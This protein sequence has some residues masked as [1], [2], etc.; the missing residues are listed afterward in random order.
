MELISKFIPYK[1]K[2]VTLHC[3]IVILIMTCIVCGLLQLLTHLPVWLLNQFVLPVS[4]SPGLH[5]SL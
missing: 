1:F 2:L 4:E 3:R 5:P